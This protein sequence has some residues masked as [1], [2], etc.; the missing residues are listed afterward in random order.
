MVNV[1]LTDEEYKAW[2]RIAAAFSEEDPMLLVQRGIGAG[3]VANASEAIRRVARAAMADLPG[4]VYNLMP[5]LLPDK[6]RG[7]ASAEPSASGDR[8]E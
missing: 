4:V 1:K 8:E 7:A 6:Q 2:Q 3:E 5:Y